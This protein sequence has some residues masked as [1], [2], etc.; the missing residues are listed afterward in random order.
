MWDRTKT[1]GITL[2]H[3]HVCRLQSLAARWHPSALASPHWEPPR[4]TYQ[5]YH[6]AIR[7]QNESPPIKARRRK[8]KHNG[9]TRC[10]PPPYP[11]TPPPPS[12]F[13]PPL[14]YRP[15]HGHPP[16]LWTRPAR[17]RP[18]LRWGRPNTPHPIPPFVPPPA[19]VRIFVPDSTTFRPLRHPPPPSPFSRASVPLP[20]HAIL[21]LCHSC[22]R[23]CGSTAHAPAVR[24]AA[25]DSR[26]PVWPRGFGWEFRPDLPL[27][28]AGSDTIRRSRVLLS[29]TLDAARSY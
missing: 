17:S 24:S 21:S 4:L 18:R 13:V 27:A 10:P 7:R 12:T 15:L 11:P 16:F 20:V 2:A 25:L 6:R 14:A 9:F 19:R 23:T 1:R 26:P 28:S 8:K 5:C 29:H 3:P 22:L